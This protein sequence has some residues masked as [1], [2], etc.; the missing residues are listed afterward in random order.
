M[1]RILGNKKLMIIIAAVAVLFVAAAVLFFLKGRNKEPEVEEILPPEPIEAPI[2]YA[3][4]DVKFLAL[5]T[6]EKM[7]V[8]DLE[9]D[10]LLTLAQEAKAKAEEAQK[11]DESSAP[12]VT[13]EDES[14]TPPATEEDTGEAEEE[15]KKSEEDVPA[16]LIAYRYEGMTDAAGLVQA[17]VEL[18]TATD[19]GFL[20]A[21]ETLM[22]LEDSTQ[23]KEQEE[24]LTMVEDPTTG[25]LVPVA[26]PPIPGVEPEKE[27]VGGTYWLVQRLPKPEEG[28][29]QAI[30]LRLVWDETTCEVTAELVPASMT[31]RPKPSS[32]IG[33]YGTTLTF[34]SAVDTIKGMH[35]SV[36][37][38]EGESMDGYRIYSRDGLVLINGQSCMRIDIYQRDKSTGTNIAAGNYFISADGLH[39]YN[40]NE[41]AQTVRELSMTT[42]GVQHTGTY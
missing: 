17:Y 2:Q 36:L 31:I 1:K 4:G 33:S 20:Y 27:P 28:E 11:K 29:R 12:S 37:E 8:Y 16:T 18:L 42:D 30:A 9:A 39:L 38:L 10:S 24:S 14:A 19:L 13:E 40:F 41:Q 5:P 7:L 34:S 25:E 3:L 22:E 6:G 32:P 23:P 21:D 26:P 35:P 15:E